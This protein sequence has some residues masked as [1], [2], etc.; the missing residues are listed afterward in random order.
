MQQG[1]PPPSRLATKKKKKG[2]LL[3]WMLLLGVIALVAMF[4]AGLNFGWFG[5]SGSGSGSGGNGNGEY[6]DP[7]Q[8]TEPYT[9]EDPPEETPAPPAYRIVTVVENNIYIDGDMIDSVDYLADWLYGTTLDDWRII[10]MQGS[11]AAMRDVNA[12][13]YAEFGGTPDEIPAP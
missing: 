3:K 9:P 12:V 1:F 8:P 10:D 6:N 2:K 13:F 11:V 7:P 4:I 5:G